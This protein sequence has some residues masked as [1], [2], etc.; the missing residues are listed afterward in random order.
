MSMVDQ[1]I[2]ANAG[3]NS[4]GATDSELD[5]AATYLGIELPTDYRSMMRRANGGETEFGDA[6]I[7]LWQAGELAEHNA[8]Y[9]VQE[10]APGFH[11]LRVRRWR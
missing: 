9:Q 1:W 4:A 3:T 10:F 8:G 6:W 2:A 11:L 5:A 7:R